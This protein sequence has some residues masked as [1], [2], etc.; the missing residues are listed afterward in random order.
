MHGET[1]K[2]YYVRP[3]AFSFSQSTIRKG[4]NNI[5]IT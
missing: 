1:V 5:I 3:I 2:F 4:F